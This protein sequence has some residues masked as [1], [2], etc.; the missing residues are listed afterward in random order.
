[1]SSEKNPGSTIPQPRSGF[2][3]SIFLLA[4]V[5]SPIIKIVMTGL[6]A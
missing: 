5:E 2:P 6:S 1:M 3:P 4:I